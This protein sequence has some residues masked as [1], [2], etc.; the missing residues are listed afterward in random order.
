M[1]ARRRPPVL[2]GWLG[3]SL[4][5]ALPAPALA[6]KVEA[7]R[8]LIAEGKLDTARA[9]CD[10]WDTA[11]LFAEDPGLREACAEA[12][13][14]VAEAADTV[15]AWEGFRIRWDGTAWGLRAFE[16]E[17]SAALRDLEDNA[18]EVVLEKLSKRYATTRTGPQLAE[19]RVLAAIRDCPTNQ[20]ARR[21]AETWPDHPKLPGLVERFPE[22]FLTIDFE[23]RKAFVRIDPP[24]PLTGDL[25]PELSWV[26]RE[27]AD[28]TRPWDEA[29]IEWLV[30]W[31]VPDVVV[32]SFAPPEE[33]GPAFPFC[34]QP[35]VPRRSG[36]GVLATVGEG[37]LV[38]ELGYEAGCSPDDWPGFLVL[39][40]GQVTGL[41]LRP[42]HGVDLR[43][44]KD[45]RDRTTIRGYLG[46]P[47]GVPQLHNGVVLQGLG[48]AW[49]G[50]PVSGGMPWATGRAP[51]AMSL[52]LTPALKT[53]PMPA[54]W[55]VKS[56]DDGL[57]VT[58][59]AL[60]KMPPALRNWS[61]H[62]DEA[63]VLAPILRGAFGLRA[64]QAVPPSPAAPTLGPAGGWKRN[65]DGS[66]RREPPE[67]ADIAGIRPVEGDALEASLGV[68]AGVGLSRDRIEP[69]DAWRVD[70]DADRTPEVIIRARIDG[71]G[72]VLV[73]DP[74]DVDE[75]YTADKARI[76][77]FAEPKVE[78]NG[79][80]AELPFAFRKGRFVYLA[81]GASEVTGR[82]SREHAI[83]VVRSDGTGV[84]SESWPLP[85]P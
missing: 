67:G 74:I 49:I 57:L 20:D 47:R 60:S 54:G 12:F 28:H 46:E 83:V 22:A 50:D 31:G 65:P 68:V 13:W 26:L 45:G 38:R 59:T 3:L 64:Q 82:T 19:A 34:H 61:L 9:R 56:S 77:A 63:R 84:M 81:W 11:G 70:V 24:V 29:A 76:F 1:K 39:E 10:K 75:A 15:D 16:R 17:A 41:S 55:S 21:I 37:K 8:R 40:D 72:A 79:R 30:G 73:V 51:A 23:R 18:T 71:E 7:A 36:P 85:A 48:P 4:A 2:R 27:G 66:I 52:P 35:G 78:A 58:G 80:A 33:G 5:L 14:P 43:A 53:A 69:L 25:V 62:G 32:G 42:G 44:P 6:A